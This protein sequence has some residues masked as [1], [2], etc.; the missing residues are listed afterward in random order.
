MDEDTLAIVVLAGLFL[1]ILSTP[2]LITGCIAASSTRKWA[3]ERRRTNL[4]GR[5]GSKTD[6]IEADARLIDEESDSDAEADF[7]DSED[8]EYYNIKRERKVKER[9]G[10]EADLRLSMGAKFVK[11]WKKCWTGAGSVETR[12]QEQE[13]RDEES[14]R[15]I[16]REAVREYLRIERKKARKAARK[17]DATN[18]ETELPTYGSAVKA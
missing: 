15:K 6:D 2:F 9:E 10:R 3:A 14:R 13:F 1:T 4:T 17:V 12:K 18:D 8:E 16:A 7:L 5:P 11:E